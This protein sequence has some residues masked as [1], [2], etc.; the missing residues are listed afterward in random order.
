VKRQAELD[1]LRGIACLMVVFFHFLYR[2]QID[3]WTGEAVYPSVAPIAKF[4]YLGVHLFFMISGYVIYKSAL[5]RSAKE[6]ASGRFWRLFPAY[7]AAIVLTSCVVYALHGTQFQISSKDLLWNFTMLHGIFGMKS[8]DGAYWS[9]VV[10]LVFYCYV[11]LAIKLNLLHRTK[12]IA[13]VWLALCLAN[14]VVD[15]HW[16]N[17]LFLTRWAPLFLVGIMA[18]KVREGDRS[19]SSWAVLAAAASVAVFQSFWLARSAAADSADRLEWIFIIAL[20][21]IFVTIVHRP[22][23]VRPSKLSNSFGDL[24]YPVYLT[25]QNIGFLLLATYSGLI[26]SWL[27]LGFALLISLALGFILNQLVER[28]LTA[29][30]R[31]IAFRSVK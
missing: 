12:G 4:G 3:H 21:A 1:Y 13:I 8:V 9:L 26:G 6:F 18:F 29:K 23:Q 7:W 27:A 16:I 2:G 24:T 22:R 25:H 10:E 28:R 14:F 31:K 20:V 11:G 17:T 30:M 19:V 5:G 15:S